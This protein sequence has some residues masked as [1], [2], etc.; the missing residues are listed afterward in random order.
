MLKLEDVRLINTQES[1]N[2]YKE[3]WVKVRSGSIFGLSQIRDNCKGDSGIL[4]Q[5]P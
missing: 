1:D 5:K 4:V 3:S 2:I